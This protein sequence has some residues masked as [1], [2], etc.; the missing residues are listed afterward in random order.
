[1]RCEGL[2]FELDEDRVGT[3]F[4]LDEATKEKLKALSK[5]TGVPQTR[6]I[7]YLVEKVSN[8]HHERIPCTPSDQKTD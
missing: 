8:E 5:A 1:M 3:S 2:D 4:M 6:I 7:D